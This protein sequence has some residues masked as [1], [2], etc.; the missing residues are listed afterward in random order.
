M[1]AWEPLLPPAALQH[2]MD[3]LVMPR[4]RLAVQARGALG[5]TVSMAGPVWDVGM[6][7]GMS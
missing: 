7:E 5:W 6:R 4:L 3:S 1:E 2:V